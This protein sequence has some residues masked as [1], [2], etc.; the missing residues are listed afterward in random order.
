[1]KLHPFLFHPIDTLFAFVAGRK[2][3]FSKGWGSKKVLSR[4]LK[5]WFFKKPQAIK[6]LLKKRKS[7]LKDIE[8]QEII[9]NSPLSESL[10]HATNKAHA[11]W[12]K[13]SGNETACVFLAG[14]REEGYELRKSIY[15]PLLELGIDLV[16]PENPFCGKRRPVYQTDFS[17][18]TVSDQALLTIAMVEEGRSL[19]LWLKKMGY[20]KLIVAGFSLGGI[21]ATMTASLTPF[22]VGLCAMAAGLSPYPAFNEY[23]LSYTIDYTQ[24]IKPA[25]SA[26]KAKEKVARLFDQASLDQFPKPKLAHKSIVLG[27]HM[28]GFI[29]KEETEKL[30]LYLGCELRWIWAGHIS[31][32]FT[33]RK[34]LRQ[35]ILDVNELIA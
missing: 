22:E 25:E 15:S 26:A 6:V 29:S 3:M 10:P 17:V 12:L 9:F 14:S 34:A 33:E 5:H 35:A 20:K 18:K 16:I 30:A 8:E 7:N 23:L 27:C 21:M 24:L 13:K 28:D 2:K 19:L 32:L 11:L 31:A 4:P 1:M